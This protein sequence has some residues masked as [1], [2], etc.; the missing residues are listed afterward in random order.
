MKLEKMLNA[1]PLLI[2]IRYV[3]DISCNFEF[4]F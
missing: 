1:G 3:C 4:Q 2:V